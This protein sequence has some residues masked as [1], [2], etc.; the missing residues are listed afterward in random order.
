MGKKNFDPMVAIYYLKSTLFWQY[1]ILCPS[2]DIF[3]E[4]RSLVKSR[5]LLSSQQI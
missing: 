1:Y 4:N 2:N 5:Q 3:R